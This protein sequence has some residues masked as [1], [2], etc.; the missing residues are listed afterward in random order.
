[1]HGESGIAWQIGRV[2]GN[3]THPFN[4]VVSLPQ[5]LP[6]MTEVLQD[7]TDSDCRSIVGHVIVLCRDQINQVVHNNDG[8]VAFGSPDF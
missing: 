4:H 5:Q 6:V 3:R 8:D 1:M 2:V 7:Y